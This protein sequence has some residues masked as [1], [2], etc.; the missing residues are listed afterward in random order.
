MAD[1]DN[2]DNDS[3]GLG[4]QALLEKE[5]ANDDAERVAVPCYWFTSA[6]AADFARKQGLSQNQA[7]NDVYFVGKVVGFDASMRRYMVMVPGDAV[8][9]HMSEGAFKLYKRKWFTHGQIRTDGYYVFGREEVAVVVEAENMEDDCDFEEGPE[10]EECCF[11]CMAVAGV[12]RCVMCQGNAFCAEHG[13]PDEF[14]CMDCYASGIGS[15][16]EDEDEGLGG[17]I[18]DG[19][20]GQSV[21]LHD[22][23][24]VYYWGCDGCGLQRHSEKSLCSSCKRNRPM[25]ESSDDESGEGV[26]EEVD[27]YGERLV[28][29]VNDEGMKGYCVVC[30]KW[31]GTMTMCLM[32]KNTCCALHFDYGQECCEL[33]SEEI[34]HHMQDALCS[35]CGRCDRSEDEGEKGKLHLCDQCMYAFCM[36]DGCGYK[37]ECY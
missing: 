26:R 18:N 29:E 4:Y 33:C 12:R 15:E 10:D 34:A 31:E 35:A 11:E 22:D 5:L 8:V 21:R 19:F 2:E 17:R 20:I 24:A 23:D 7:K 25:P 30:E 9:Y 37:R 3:A 1:G 28:L 16:E 32:C 6:Y 14:K 36:K 27:R 13:S